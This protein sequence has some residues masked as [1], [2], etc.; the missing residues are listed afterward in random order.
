MMRRFGRLWA[1]R[2]PLV[3]EAQ[4]PAAVRVEGDDPTGEVGAVDRIAV[5]A[6]WSPDARVG[7]S[8]TQ[9]MAALAGGGYGVV[10]VSTSVGTGHLEWAVERP[11]GVTVLR[12]PN[13]GYDFGSWATALDRFPAI[14]TS[15]YVLLLNDS[16]VGPFQPIDHL[17]E[18]FDQSAADVW[19]M[20]DT[21]QFRHH[22]QSYC[23]GFKG[24]SLREP[25]L[26]RFWRTIRVE[27]SRE[28]VIWR[29]ELGLSQLLD[30]ERFVTE[31]AIPYW[32]V[33]GEKQNPT[34]LG[35]RRLLDEGFPFVKRQLLREPHIAPEG[36]QVSAEIRRRYGVEVDDWM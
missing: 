17:L 33:V 23:L 14:A 30:R 27:G 8:A 10:L 3:L 1:G 12:R 16:L 22:L 29:Y 36:A 24:G 7:R 9:L 28:D 35:W 26:S 18:R 2:G 32:R 19:G 13:I 15:P 4:S 20:T 21:T 11:P 6:H 25:S 34:I 31:A 5:L